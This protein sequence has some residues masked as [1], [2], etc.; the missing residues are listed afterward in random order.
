MI[1][2]LLHDV[3][4]SRFATVA[5]GLVL[6]PLA[7]AHFHDPCTEAIAKND[8]S[9]QGVSRDPNPPFKT[10]RHLGHRHFK[11]DRSANSGGN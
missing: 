2:P 5:L 6:L 11:P 8:S 1:I 3:C 10:Y 9:S 4:E 7:C